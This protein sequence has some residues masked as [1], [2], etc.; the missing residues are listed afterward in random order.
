MTQEELKKLKR[1]DLLEMLIEQSKENEKIRKKLDEAEKELENRKIAIKK[2][3][4]IV[5]AAFQLNHVF[6][7]AEKA[8]EQYIEN[9][10][11]RDPDEVDIKAEVRDYCMNMIKAA[12]K[13]CSAVEAETRER[14]EE[15]VSDAKRRIE[16]YYSQ[17]TGESAH[18]DQ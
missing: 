12:E 3:G 6:E 13:K 11:N 17:L 5:Q 18:T 14:C 15:I 4:S 10:F 2:S 8:K 16:S 1:V 7:A 9:L